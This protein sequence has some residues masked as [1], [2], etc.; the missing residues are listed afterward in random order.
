MPYL[1]HI[2]NNLT[3]HYSYA[4][5]LNFA[6]C[7]EITV[8]T[9]STMAWKHL[10]WLGHMADLNCEHGDERSILSNRTITI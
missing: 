4:V 5:C 3:R 6:W 7:H 1:R 10:N 8:L 2:A 9:L